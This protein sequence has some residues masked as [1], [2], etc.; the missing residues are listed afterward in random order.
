MKIGRMHLRP[1]Y[2]LLRPTI[3]VEK[4]SVGLV[5]KTGVK[6]KSNLG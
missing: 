5:S 1:N 4:Y 2:G 3:E 6:I